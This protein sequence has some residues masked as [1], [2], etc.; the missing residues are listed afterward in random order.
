MDAF[1]VFVDRD[2]RPALRLAYAFVGPKAEDVVQEAMLKAYRNL[3]RYR[4]APSG[5]RPWLLRIVAN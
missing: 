5:F 2:Q 3:H 4:P 1:A